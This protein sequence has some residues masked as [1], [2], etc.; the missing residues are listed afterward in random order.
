MLEILFH[1][2]PPLTKRYS[3]NIKLISVEQFWSYRPFK[4]VLGITN[5]LSCPLHHCHAQF[6]QGA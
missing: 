4:D 2:K 6:L 1:H 3:Q 5:F